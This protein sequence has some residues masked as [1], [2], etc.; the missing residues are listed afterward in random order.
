MYSKN[1]LFVQLETDKFFY[2]SLT[3]LYFQVLDPLVTG[4]PADQKNLEGYL[5]RMENA[6]ESFDSLWLGQGHKFITGENI[7]VADL[8]AACEVE[9]PSEYRFLIL[10][11][12]SMSH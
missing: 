12:S 6:L 1:L 11:S 3:N 2:L 10:K 9:Q 7:T 4:R 8:L 5:R